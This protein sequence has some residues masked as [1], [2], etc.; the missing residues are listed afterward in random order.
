MELLEVDIVDAP[1]SH[2][3]S[4]WNVQPPLGGRSQLSPAGYRRNYDAVG[5]PIRRCQSIQ[6]HVHQSGDLENY[7]LSHW[8]PMKVT[9]HWRNVV[10]FPSTCDK[11]C[12]RVLD[13]LQT[14][15]EFFADTVQ[16]TVAVVKPTSYKRLCQCFGGSVV[17][18]ITDSPQ[19]PKL[20]EAQTLQNILKK[21]I[22]K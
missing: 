11:P 5:S 2:C 8:Q 1:R 17:N 7:H 14:S 3:P 16:Q 20:E 18:E 4:S 22:T 6:I 19:L 9:Q 10:V 21:L 13:T 12:R 15:Q